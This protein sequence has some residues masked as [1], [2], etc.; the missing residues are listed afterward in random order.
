MNKLI[1]TIA[2]LFSASMSFA[3][4]NKGFISEEQAEEY[5]DNKNYECGINK[6]TY[7]AS[8][9][10]YYVT[11]DGE[12]A[13]S[14]LYKLICEGSKTKKKKGYTGGACSDFSCDTK[15]K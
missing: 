11:E 8:S 13:S 6:S 10:V 5:L 14:Y 9:D 12:E 1:L 15:G 4:N 7:H 2:I 3:L